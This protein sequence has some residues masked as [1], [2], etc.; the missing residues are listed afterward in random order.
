MPGYIDSCYKAVMNKLI[1][2]TKENINK[3]SSGT[4][5]L[6]SFSDNYVNDMID[7]F[8]RNVV[9]RINCYIDF[10]HKGTDKDLNGKIIN[11]I[12]IDNVTLLSQDADYIIVDDYY[13]EIYE[14]YV[15][16][17]GIDKDIYFFANKETS[18]D[19]DYRQRYE[20]VP[21]KN[22]IL[23]RSG[24]H[25]SAY[26]K[27]TDFSD[28]A[29]AVFEYMLSVGL[30]EKYELVW[31]VK[32]PDEFKHIE[33]NYPG[34]RFLSFD[35]SVSDVPQNRDAYYEALCLS[36]YIFFTDA[37]GFCRNA[38]KDQ[39]RIQLW[40]GC[41]F[42]T[43]VNFVRCEDR[44]EYMPVI[45][46]VYAEIHKK[47]YGLRDDQILI[48]GYP[49]EDTIFHPRRDWKE[50]LGIKE[51]RKYI[52]W[53]PTF[54]KTDVNNLAE[55]DMYQLSGETGLPI[56][57]NIND[58]SKLDEY[59]RAQDMF[60]VLK[61]HPFQDR[62]L[63]NIPDCSNIVF[64]DNE[65]LVNNDIQINEILGFADAL[66]SDYSSVAVDYLLLDRPIAFLID[67]IQE[68]ENKRGFVFEPIREWLPGVEIKTFSELYDFIVEISKDIDSSME[69]RRSISKQMH[70]FKD[71][72][73]CKRLIEALG[74]VV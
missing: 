32:N 49:K 46:P 14:K 69:K 59:L 67:D 63:I 15:Q 40:H 60:L 73:S 25:A 70:S 21:L 11:C 62:S 26:I 7:E 8:G 44:Y 71:D 39:I 64:I 22:I 1:R 55:V 13:W 45:S 19:L 17:L 34:A 16:K 12:D 52:F 3:I 54:R 42:K 68:Y 4:I 2:I 51:A 24:P 23:F 57:K 53:L 47:I 5:Y 20:N 72:Q 43:R 31:L 56:A 50:L 48:T 9:E 65:S 61:L 6:L 27:G 28:N 58:L 37:Y 74:I 29:R 38:R 10:S 33:D 30:N 36:K 41:G 18:Y 35:W 66:I